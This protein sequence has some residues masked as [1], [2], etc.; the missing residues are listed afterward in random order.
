MAAGMGK[1]P[2]VEQKYLI[3]APPAKVFAALTQPRQLARWFVT[4]AV[5]DLR[6]GGDYRLSWAPEVGM[7]GK[8]R[9]FT[10]PTKLVV[11]WH[12][13][14]PGGKAFDTVAR[15]RLRKRGKATV[16]TVTHDGFRSGK[17][18]VPLF[19]AVQSGWAYYLQNLKS[20]LEHGT[21]LRTDI[22]QL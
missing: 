14:M 13:K 15:F 4:S 12:D 6:A 7:K 8:V 20:V 10:A 18:W 11:D 3:G 5:V 17:S 9:S 21:D 16:L 22:D 2:P 19:G 1:L